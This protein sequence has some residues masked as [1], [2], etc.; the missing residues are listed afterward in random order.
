MKVLYTNQALESL[1]EL[2]DFLR[3]KLKIPP[4]LVKSYLNS[5]LD[6]AD[7]IGDHPFQYPLEPYLEPL[8]LRHRRKIHKHVKIIFRVHDD[9]VLITD[10]FDS[11]QDPN[12]MKG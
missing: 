1:E 11:R 5:L 9:Y 6:D 7:E 8:N 12:K 4:N 10:F 3:V 2:S